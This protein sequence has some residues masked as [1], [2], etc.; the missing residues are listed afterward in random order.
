MVK[1]AKK[2]VHAKCSI[3]ECDKYALE[4]YEGF[5]VCFI[6]QDKLIDEVLCAANERIT[7]EQM[8]LH[9]QLGILVQIEVEA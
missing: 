7:V 4:Q 1:W 8:V 9:K 5:S 3:P 2:T 6:C